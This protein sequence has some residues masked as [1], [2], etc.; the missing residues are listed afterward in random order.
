LELLARFVCIFTVGE[1]RGSARSSRREQQ[2]T[3]LLRFHLSNLAQR[4]VAAEGGVCCYPLAVTRKNHR[5]L[6]SSIFSTAAQAAPSLYPPPA[7]VGLATRFS[8]AS[9]VQSQQRK[10]EKT[11][12][13]S[14]LSFLELLARFE[15][16]TS[17]LPRI[18]G[19]CPHEVSS[20][21][22]PEPLVSQQVFQLYY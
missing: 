6:R 19:L 2:S 22:I 12:R 16:A 8:L 21:T 14:G 13:M 3:G 9:P 15:L 7:A 18:W 20:Q 17:S 5:I 1:N 11:T 4:K 10:K